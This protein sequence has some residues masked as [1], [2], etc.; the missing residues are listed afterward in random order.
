MLR[1]RRIGRTVLNRLADEGNPAVTMATWYAQMLK[2][3]CSRLFRLQRGAGSVQNG[4]S[5][6]DSA[7]RASSLPQDFTSQ[8]ASARS[9]F[10]RVPSHSTCG[11]FGDCF[12][13]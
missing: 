11:H 6:H 2:L 1:E 5:C 10:S 8:R 3:G 13:R 9:I 12:L 4:A 7:A